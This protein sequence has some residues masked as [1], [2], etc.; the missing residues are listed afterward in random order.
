[1]TIIV[2][3]LCWVKVAQTDNFDAGVTAHCAVLRSLLT[4]TAVWNS[5]IHSSLIQRI[6]FT[7][8]H[9]HQGGTSLD[10]LALKIFI[11]SQTRGKYS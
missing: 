4:V 2:L 5:V 3:N 6:T 10:V 11:C 8:V 9:S 1:M 7:V